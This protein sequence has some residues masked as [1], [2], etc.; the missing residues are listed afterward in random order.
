MWLDKL[1]YSAKSGI[2]VVIR[3]SFFGG[4]YGMISSDLTPNPD[5]W[6]SV[7]FKKFVSNKVLD[8][9]TPNNFSKLRLNAHC[10]QDKALLN[11][12][13]ATTIFGVNINEISASISIQG[14]PLLPQSAIFFYALTA[15]N[16]QSRYIYY[17]Y[18]LILLTEIKNP[19]FALLLKNY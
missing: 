15:S 14:V 8:L 4:N 11:G 1:G 2:R 6:I 16:L 17:I 19:K 5:W 12:V 9:L 18:I 10:T 13:P 3:Q 7:V